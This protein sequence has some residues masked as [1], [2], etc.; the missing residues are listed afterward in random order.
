MSF[1][2]TPFVC[3]DH[4]PTGCADYHCFY[5]CFQRL[6]KIGTPFGVLKKNVKRVSR[7]NSTIFDYWDKPENISYPLY[8]WIVLVACYCALHVVC[9]FLYRIAAYY[10]KWKRDEKSVQQIFVELVKYVALLFLVYLST[11]HQRMFSCTIDHTVLEYCIPFLISLFT[12][13]FLCEVSYL[14]VRLIDM[15]HWGVLTWLI[16]GFIVAFLLFLVIFCFTKSKEMKMYFVPVIP[17]LVYFLAG[18]VVSLFAHHPSLKFHPRSYQLAYLLCLLR[19]DN[20]FY[21]RL[22]A[23]VTEGFFLRCVAANPMLSLLEPEEQGESVEADGP[24]MA[25]EPPTANE[26]VISIPSEDA[27]MSENSLQRPLIV[28]GEALSQHRSREN[29][30]I[31][32][33]NET[34]LEEDE[35]EGSFRS[36][37]DTSR[38][39]DY[40]DWNDQ[41]KEDLL[42]DH[43]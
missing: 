31:A 39:S 15:R 37:L 27:G 42:G 10:F 21:C 29:G 8:V 32:E 1:P 9:Y 4:V 24:E 41:Q 30:I 3:W 35:K 17:M 5:V 18:F 36:F 34:I 25:S 13:G 6:S 20:D 33:K 16:L 11:D 26:A 28:A 23:G 12:S 43:D 7:M 22:L 40:G 14:R 38:A 2:F 19:K